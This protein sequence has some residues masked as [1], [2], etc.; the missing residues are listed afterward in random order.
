[1][2][3]DA[4]HIPNIRISVNDSTACEYLLKSVTTT[5]SKVL[6]LCNTLTSM[7]EYNYAHNIDKK[8]SYGN[9]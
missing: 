9:R 7:L 6:L 3:R 8:S 4:L 1:M 2:K 5:A